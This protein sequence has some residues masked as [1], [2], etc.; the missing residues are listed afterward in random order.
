MSDGGENARTADPTLEP[1]AEAP[2]VV[3]AGHIN[4][5]VT[6]HVDELPERDG[7]TRIERL[8]Q[9]GGGSAANVA[10]GLGGLGGRAAVFGSVGG[11]ESGALAL[12][13][14]ASAGVDPGHVLVDADAAT[15]VTYVIV[16]GD[17]E[18]LL[19]ANDGANESF[20]ADGLDRGVLADAD[21]LH[22]TGQR[23]D[24]AAALATTAAEVG[25]TRSFDPGR[26]VADR[27]YDAALRAADLI[28][29]NDREASALA[30]A[31][32]IDPR[33]PAERVVAVKHGG[34]GAT[35]HTPRGDISHPGFDV[36]AVDTAGAG[37]A[38]AA[39][40]LAAALRTPEIA[41][42]GFATDPREYGVPLLV[43]NACGAIAAGTVT[44]RA[45]LSWDRVRSIAGESPE[46]DLRVEIRA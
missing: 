13:E 6:I 21:H 39:G 40:F 44:A 9:S 8:E 31:T 36:D 22:L 3:S 29:V 25:P 12:R 24:T 20:S 4:W 11:D 30:D 33:T 38:F 34:D 23:P 27:E 5:D 19:L 16:D 2:T 35:V 15:S 26:R 10:V 28:F 41:A 37:D 32:D 43:A 42:D 14:L 7:E 18:L 1:P 46:A 17:G 45:D